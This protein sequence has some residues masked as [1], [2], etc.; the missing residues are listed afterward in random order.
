MGRWGACPASRVGRWGACPASRVGRWGACPASRVGRWV[1]HLP[2]SRRETGSAV[3]LDRRDLS[4]DSSDLSVLFVSD[5][6]SLALEV[7]EVEQARLANDA[8]RE[9]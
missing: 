8:P 7:A 5:A 1:E 4:P 9:P 6:G 2:A 3:F